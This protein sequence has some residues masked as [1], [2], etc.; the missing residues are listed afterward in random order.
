MNNVVTIDDIF[1]KP[2]GTDKIAQLI[3][4]QYNWVRMGF[5]WRKY[6]IEPKVDLVY[7]STKDSTKPTSLE[8]SLQTERRAEQLIRRTYGRVHSTHTFCSSTRNNH[9]LE[10]IHVEQRGSEGSKFT[11]ITMPTAIYDNL[12]TAVFLAENASNLH[13]VR[14]PTQSAEIVDLVERII[15][16]THKNSDD[17]FEQ[18]SKIGVKKRLPEF[19]DYFGKNFTHEKTKCVYYPAQE[20]VQFKTLAGIATEE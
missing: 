6:L 20:Q 11:V 16:G 19:K 12:Q 9:L 17:A 1:N 13:P 5:S 4:G 7:S 10:D 3:Q 2:Q 14:Y 15:A 8:F 18:R